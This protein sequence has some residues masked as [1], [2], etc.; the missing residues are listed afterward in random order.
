MRSTTLLLLAAFPVA[1]AQTTILPVLSYSS[2][3]GFVYGARIDALLD[4]RPGGEF[5]AMAYWTTRGG[6]YQTLTAAVPGGE[7]SWRLEASHDQVLD[8]DF[9]GWGNW[10]DPDTSLEYDREMDAFYLG[11]SQRLG[12]RFV[13]GLGIEARHSVTFDREEG[14]LWETLPGLQTAS[15]WTAG[16]RAELLFLGCPLA[17]LPGYT[18]ATFLHQSGADISYSRAVIEKAVFVPFLRGN[19]LALHYSLARHWGAEETPFPFLPS[20][21]PDEVLRGYAD[22]RFFGPVTAVANVE[23]QRPLFGFLPSGQSPLP[24][25]L[26]GIALYADAGQAAEEM[27]GIRWD[28]YHG[29]VGAGLRFVTGM[30]KVRVDW[31]FLSP[32]GMKLQL[33]FGEAF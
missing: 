22:D 2:S 27:G 8:A 17:G 10:G 16:P 24:S 15:T 33:G 7:N 14:G 26:F 11:R 31:T 28:R 32:E 25:A 21:G 9:Y 4:G 12:G 13:A 30:T 29:D 19:I 18:S 5:S 20:L 6:Q 1:L 23:I 3:S